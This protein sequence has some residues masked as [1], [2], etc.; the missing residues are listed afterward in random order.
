M[1]SDDAPTTVG[2]LPRKQHRDWPTVVLAGAIALAAVFLAALGYALVKQANIHYSKVTAVVAT[3]TATATVTQV[4]RVPAPY[5]VVHTR[6]RYL[7]APRVTVTQFAT[8]APSP[9]PTPAPTPQPS[10]PGV[11]G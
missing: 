9:E 4:Q 1:T 6:Y 2:Q 10:I 11:P 5:P 3:H 8:P 7:P